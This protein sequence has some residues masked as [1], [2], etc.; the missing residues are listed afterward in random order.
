MIL[1]MPGR[2]QFA[3]DALEGDKRRRM[4]L[5]LDVER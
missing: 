3:L 1:H 2:W 4:T 5:D